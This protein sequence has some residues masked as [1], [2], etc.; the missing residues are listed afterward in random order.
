MCVQIIH[1]VCVLWCLYMIL[2]FDLDLFDLSLQQNLVQDFDLNNIYHTCKKYP[3]KTRKDKEKK[4][5]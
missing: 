2:Q 3:L 1:H 5:N 4:D